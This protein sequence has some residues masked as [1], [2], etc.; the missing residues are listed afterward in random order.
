MLRQKRAVV[1][2]DA[3]VARLHLDALLQSLRGAGVAIESIVLPSGEGTKSF[4]ELESLCDRLLALKA[5][6]STTLIALGGGVV[7][8][9]V[10]TS[11]QK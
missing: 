9:G 8:E 2:T 4:A 1:I 3:Q 11:A 6:R 7:G 10:F 5:E